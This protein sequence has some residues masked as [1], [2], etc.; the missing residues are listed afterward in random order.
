MVPTSTTPR[1]RPEPSR[2][3]S[4]PDDCHRAAQRMRPP[5]APAYYQGR[6]AWFWLAR[7]RPG[8]P[9]SAVAARTPYGASTPDG[10][11]DKAVNPGG[12]SK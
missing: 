12:L 7:F 6:P 1:T 4:V 2:S 8:W 11:R 10:A 9:L 3:S 5:T